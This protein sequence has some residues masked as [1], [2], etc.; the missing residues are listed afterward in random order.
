MEWLLQK[1][2]ETG[3]DQKMIDAINH[4]ADMIKQQNIEILALG[5][6]LM[7]ALIYIIVNIFKIHEFD[8]RLKKLEK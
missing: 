8:K 2:I 6:G 3:S 7:I 1:A 4:Q 5:V